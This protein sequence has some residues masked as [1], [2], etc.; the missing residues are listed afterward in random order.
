MTELFKALG[1]DNRLAILAL[2]SDQPLCGCD[3]EENLNL[4]QSN[5]SRH[6]S[7]LKN[8]NIVKSYKTQQWV[9]FAIHQTFIDENLA[10]WL[11]LK[12]SFQKEPYQTL[13]KKFSAASNCSGPLPVELTA[14][15]LEKG[16]L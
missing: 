3:L 10:L 15:R 16:E 6:L 7:I 8:A 12:D 13:R 5:V 4:S 14:Y 2:L 1:H 11:Y 9:Y